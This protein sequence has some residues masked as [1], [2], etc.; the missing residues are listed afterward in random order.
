[1]DKPVYGVHMKSTWG[2]YHWKKNSITKKPELKWF[3][4]AFRL[5]CGNYEEQYIDHNIKHELVHWYTDITEGKP[6]HHNK[7]WKDNCRKFGIEDSRLS[8]YPKIGAKPPK[9]IYIKPKKRKKPVTLGKNKFH[10]VFCIA[11]RRV[12]VKSKNYQKLKDYIEDIK[13]T[14]ECGGRYIAY[15]NH[16]ENYTR[17]FPKTHIVTKYG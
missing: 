5:I 1:M 15:G 3:K 7:K 8:N 11:C 6:C 9:E 12:I 4:I 13:P 10:E 16:K 14:C 2:S 17:V